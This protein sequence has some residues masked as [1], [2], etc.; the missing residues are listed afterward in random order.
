MELCYYI[1][2]RISNVGSAFRLAKKPRERRPWTEE[3]V[4]YD[5]IS[6][7]VLPPLSEHSSLPDGCV[8]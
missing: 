4:A 3:A 6:F 8:R 1:K 5:L 2:T 7:Q